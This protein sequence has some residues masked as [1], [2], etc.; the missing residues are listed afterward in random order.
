MQ[1][2]FSLGKMSVP[3]RKHLTQ[4]F[5]CLLL[6]P[7]IAEEE[8]SFSHMASVD[9]AREE[10]GST[11]CTYTCVDSAFTLSPHSLCMWIHSLT[12]STLSPHNPPPFPPHIHMPVNTCMQQHTYSNI[13][14][15]TCIQQHAY[16]NMHTAT[17][18]QQHTYSNI[19]TAT[20][21]QQHAYS[22]IHVSHGV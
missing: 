17:C 16:S 13:H 9:H 1:C 6:F 14:T 15:A 19:H 2:P 3:Q 22:N 20:H 18:I 4:A 21:I 5:L 8:G 7:S 10:D 12:P 11:G